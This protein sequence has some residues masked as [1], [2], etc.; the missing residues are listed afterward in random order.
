M[1]HKRKVGMQLMAAPKKFNLVDKLK[2]A[3]EKIGDSPSILGKS[4]IGFSQYNNAMR[5]V[6]YSSHL[7]QFANLLHSEF[8]F[9]FTNFENLVGKYSDGYRKAKGNLVVYRKIVKF[10]DIVDHPEI[11]TLF[12]YNEDTEEY[13]VEIRKP[14]ENLT[15]MF[16]YGYNN[17]VIDSLE[18]G[19]TVDKGTVLYKSTSYDDYMNYG[20]GKNVLTMWT[21]DPNTSEDAAV[22]SKSLSKAL[23][24]VKGESV[25]IG[26][27][28][29]DFGL[30]LYGN[31]ERYQIF[32][33]IGEETNGVV[34]ATRRLYNDQVL[35]DFRS[36]V[37]KHYI[38]GDTEYFVDGK[39][40]DICIY[41]NNDELED[42]TFNRQIIKYLESQKRYYRDIV[43]TCEEI[44]NS[45]AK[46]TDR[47]DE[48]YARALEFLDDTKA[49][50]NR[51]SV[52][53]NLVIE[54]FVQ[55]VDPFGIGCKLTGR[56][57]NKSVCAKILDDKDMPFLEDGRRVDLLVNNLAIINRTIAGPIFEESINFICSM[58]IHHM[59]E[60]DSLKE[61]ANFLMEFVGM[62][63]KKQMKAMEKTY[64]K[65][66]T[67]ERKEYIQG[68]ISGHIYINMV[69]VGEDR[70]I[71]YKLMDIYEK[72]S[73]WLKPQDVYIRKFG[74]LIKTLQK[75]YIGEM[76]VMALKQT[77]KKG[78]SVRGMGAINNKGLPERS[79]K[80]K[81][82]MENHSTSNIRFGEFESLNF[83]NAMSPEELAL[84]HAY[85]RSSLEAR[86]DLGKQVLNPN[87]YTKIKKKYISRIGEIFEVILKSLGISMDVVDDRNELTEVDDRYISD[88]T[89]DDGVTYLCT[90]YQAFLYERI[91]A[92]KEEILRTNMVMDNES[93]K[94]QIDDRM[95]HSGYV[96]N[97][98]QYKDRIGVFVEN[99]NLFKILESNDETV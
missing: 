83:L 32:P 37:L 97:T 92:L 55:R 3:D 28:D 21:M 67:K 40:Y 8:P 23:S 1:T 44:I 94:S 4:I 70:P 81:S 80:N 88:H 77:S 34:M 61:Q 58:A 95:S 98:S 53:S 47:L 13:D 99:G 24:S 71:F 35:Y 17:E 26:L 64:S 66:S 69:P 87:G 45:G 12:V 62:L 90:N 46:Y 43:D 14:I 22:V 89:F 56:H 52:F 57:G 38:D 30:N 2:E 75:Q 6:M 54:I 36:D 15:E 96:L 78:F 19:D 63:N 73:D 7:N 42:N 31:D 5:S 29:N 86:K 41:C 68:I 84:L 27:N 72:Y 9:V 93:L 60:M 76:Y 25:M 79:Y 85:Y 59:A 50:R 48:V 33:E 11:Y 20:F 39:V 51:D 16:A 49:W 65:L 18:E 74:R 10:D 82:H 91:E